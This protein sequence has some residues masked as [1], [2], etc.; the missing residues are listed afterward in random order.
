MPEYQVVPAYWLAQATDKVRGF[1][2]L[3]LNATKV[4]TTESLQ[5]GLADIGVNYTTVQLELI[6]AE[7]VAK[8]VIEAVT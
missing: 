1:L 6:G 5:K 3:E 8:G 7:L 2:L 4:W